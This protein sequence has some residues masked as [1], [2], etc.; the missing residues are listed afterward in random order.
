MTV[1]IPEDFD[2]TD[3]ELF[4][5][6]LPHPEWRELRRTE[7]LRRVSKRPGGDGF[8][9]DHYWLATRHADVKEISRRTGEAFSAAENTMIPRFTEGTDRSIIEA[10]RAMILNEDGELHKKHRRI[11]SRGFTPRG[12]AGHRETLTA[13]ARTIVAEAARRDTADFVTAVASE[14]PLQTIAELLGIPQT[15]RHSVF[16]WSNRMTS[17]D[18]PGQLDDATVASIEML[19]YAH[20]MAESRT[21]TPTDDIVTALVQADIDGESLSPEEFGWFVTV[22]AVAGNETTRNATT[23]GM[24]AMLDNPEQWELFKAE[25]PE[26]AYDEILRWS[27]PVTQFQRTAVEDVRIGGADIAAGDR[28]LLC[29]ASANFDED[30]FDE[31]FRFDLERDPNPHVTFGGQGPHYCIGANLA[32]L[33][34]EIIFNAIADELPDLRSLGEPERLGSAWLNAITRWPISTGRCPMSD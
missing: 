9:D 23:H 34:I 7:P 6:R 2:F 15:D 22:L 29:Y 31:P 8:D 24:I 1:Y 16:D 32:R 17:Y 33:Q 3:P 21:T 10:Q 12:V 18:V 27:S 30:V 28:V 5:R 26:T 20:A 25:R 11:I 13:R 19:G 4:A 14:L